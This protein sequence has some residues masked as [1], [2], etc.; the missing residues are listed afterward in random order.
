MSLSEAQQSALNDAK[1]RGARAPRALPP[2]IPRASAERAAAAAPASPGQ[3]A[4]RQRAVPPRAP[5]A[6][7]DDLALHG[8]GCARRAAVGGASARARPLSPRPL[9]SRSLSP[10]PRAVLESKP[11]DVQTFA[12]EFFT[13]EDLVSARL[14]A[15][16]ALSRARVARSLA[17]AKFTAPSLVLGARAPAGAA[18]AGVD[19]GHHIQVAARALQMPGVR[20]GGRSYLGYAA[21]ASS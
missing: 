17:R 16:R 13:Q 9:L 19:G 1:A 11:G 15:S 8:Q 5:R 2:L 4:A 10:S 3:A 14:L 6:P 18:S 7:R 20:G 12:A 21:G